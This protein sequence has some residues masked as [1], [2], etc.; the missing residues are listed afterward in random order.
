MWT[1]T[2]GICLCLHLHRFLDVKSWSSHCCKWSE[3]FEL[4]QEET[5][6]GLVEQWPIAVVFLSVIILC[7]V[8]YASE[9]F[10]CVCKIF[11]CIARASH[12][13]VTC[14]VLICTMWPNLIPQ[15]LPS[16]STGQ[17]SSAGL[18]TCL[19][20]DYLQMAAWK[21]EYSRMLLAISVGVTSFATPH[22]LSHMTL[23]N[24]DS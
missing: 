3:N 19:S 8:M 13:S 14:C 10:V 6:V 2:T 15:T 11:H 24:Y 20:I 21:D 9:V 16:W 4:I 5:D 12:F 23:K 17:Y 1:K 22:V 18:T 7:S